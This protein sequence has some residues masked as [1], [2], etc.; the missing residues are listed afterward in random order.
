MEQTREEKEVIY[1]GIP[2]SPGIA[3][4]PLHVIAR[5]FGAPEVYEID[6][7]EIEHE[8]DRFRQAIDGQAQVRQHLVIDDVVE[9]HGVRVE[10]FL[11][12]DDAVFAGKCFVVTDN[13]ES[14]TGTVIG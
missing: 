6:D 2:A 3:M 8:Q 13:P 12:Q 5:G 7:S 9:E 14:F 10:G 4:A 11:R 1:Q